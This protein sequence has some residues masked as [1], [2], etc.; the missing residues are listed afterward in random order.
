MI[1]DGEMV[2]YIHMGY[3]SLFDHYQ[4]I[5]VEA[6]AV[7]DRRELNYEEFLA[8]NDEK[9]A[10]FQK[11]AEYQALY[12]DLSTGDRPMD[13]DSILGFIRSFYAEYYLSL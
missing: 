13:E 9:F 4:I 12:E 11:T 2:H 7:T 5:R 10:E 3:G 8:F 6:G 1:P